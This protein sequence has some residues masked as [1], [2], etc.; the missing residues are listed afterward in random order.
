MRPSQFGYDEEI[1]G[2]KNCTSLVCAVGEGEGDAPAFMTHKFVEVEGGTYLVSR[3]WMGMVT[4]D[5]FC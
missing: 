2:S 3:F 1:I 5:P 4:C